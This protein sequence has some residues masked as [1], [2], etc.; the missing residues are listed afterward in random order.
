MLSFRIMARAALGDCQNCLVSWVVGVFC[1]SS[2][3][4]STSFFS[5]TG[6]GRNPADVRETQFS[7]V[8]KAQRIFDWWNETPKGEDSKPCPEQHGE[9]CLEFG[10]RRPMFH[11]WRW[12]HSRYILVYSCAVTSVNFFQKRC[13]KLTQPCDKSSCQIHKRFFC[14]YP[15]RITGPQYNVGD[16]FE[17]IPPRGFLFNFIKA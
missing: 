3:V 9:Y 4:A 5:T 8:R 13:L 12:N 2:I 10:G 1:Q 16:G 11:V 6:R 17:S 14:V 7:L 15:I